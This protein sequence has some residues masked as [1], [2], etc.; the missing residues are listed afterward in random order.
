MNNVISTKVKIFRNLKEY[1]FSHKLSNEHRNEIVENLKQ[2]LNSKMQLIDLSEIDEKTKNFIAKSNC[3][4]KTG[5]VFAHKTDN[6]AIELFN[7]EHITIVAESENKDDSAYEKAFKIV[8]DLSNKI[9]FAFSDEYGYL[10]SNLNHIGTGVQIESDI[11]L[12]SIKAIGKIEQVKQNLAKL[13]Y[14]L[15]ETKFKGMFKIETKCNLGISEKQIV[16]DFK[17]TLAKL[18]ELEVESAK[19]LDVEKHDELLDMSNR[20]LA[21]LG[22]AYLMNYEE[23]YTMLINLRIGQTL[24]MNEV[25]EFKLNKLQKLVMNKKEEFISQTEQKTLAQQVKEILK[26][27]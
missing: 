17:N 12:L 27:E 7:D 15:K 6:L 10:M 13:G 21:I 26:G 14:T 22:N 16:S 5:L 2:T 25:S 3:I 23:L 18:Q 24:S 8:N 9:E 20:S 19:M 4:N 1:K 11:M